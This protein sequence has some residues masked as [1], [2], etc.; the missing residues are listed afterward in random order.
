MRE[1]E[2]ERG[3]LIL[4]VREREE[5]GERVNIYIYYIYY[6]SKGIKGN[7]FLILFENWQLA[8]LKMMY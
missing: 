6:N 3:G 1:K 8:Y 7:L 4:C 5:R 2:K